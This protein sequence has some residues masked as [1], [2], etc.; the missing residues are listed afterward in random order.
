[1]MLLQGIFAES[2]HDIPRTDN[3]IDFFYLGPP[4]TASTWVFECLKEHP[5]IR[6]TDHSETNYFDINFYKGED[7]YSNLY[8][9]PQGEQLTI[10]C[11]PTY[12]NSIQ[13]LE[14]ILAHNPNAK[15]SFGVRNPIERAF[16]G[17]WHV[18]RLGHINYKFEDIL[19][20]YVWFR[21]WVEP[22]LI[23]NHVA[24]LTKHVGAENIIPI[25]FDDLQKNPEPILKNLYE[26][27]KIDP[28]FTPET[29][30]KKVNVARPQN[31]LLARIGHKC[32]EKTGFKALS[33]KKE[34]L[35]GIPPAFRQE[36]NKLCTPEIEALSTLLDRDFTHWTKGTDSL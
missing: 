27:L 33:G 16:S 19:D 29:L 8:S 18:R 24:W 5:E 13:S 12:I 34:Y 10:D 17:Y 22:G 30:T 14:R 21:A 4:K 31:T 6:A 3:M 28:S 9:A 25:Y 15:F 26:F 7:W 32:F 1:M 20:T 36:L 2:K 35:E 23:S 11:T